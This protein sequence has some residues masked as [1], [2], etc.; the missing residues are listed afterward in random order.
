[1]EASAS[2]SSGV[3]LVAALAMLFS[4]TREAETD[5]RPLGKLRASEPLPRST[6]FTLQQ[7]ESLCVRAGLTDLHTC[8]NLPAGRHQGP[9]HLIRLANT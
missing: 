3:R 8:A 2:R 1:M 6:L 4:R 5:Q 9:Q 7:F